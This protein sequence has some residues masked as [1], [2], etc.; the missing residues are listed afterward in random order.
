VKVLPCLSGI[1]SRRR[2]RFENEAFGAARIDHPH[3]TPV[4]AMGTHHGAMYYAMRLIRGA[5]LA[6]IVKSLRLCGG[7]ATPVPDAEVASFWRAAARLGAQA[8]DALQAAHT[9]GIVH[10]DVKPSNLLVDS[11]GRV[12]VT[13]FGLAHLAGDVRLTVSGEFVGTPR[14]AAPETIRRR[15]G[16]RDERVDVYG[17]GVS[18]YELLARRPAFDGS[19]LYSVLDQVA[20]CRPRRL[21]RIDPRIPRELAAIVHRA[22]AKR[23]KARFTT[24]AELRDALAQFVATSEAQPLRIGGAPSLRRRVP[25]WSLASLAL[26]SVA[27]VGGICSFPRSV[28][29]LRPSG[30]QRSSENEIAADCTTACN[31]HASGLQAE[32]FREFSVLP[33]HCELLEKTLAVCRQCTAQ[34]ALPRTDLCDLGDCDAVCLAKP[35]ATLRQSDAGCPL[36]GINQNDERPPLTTPRPEG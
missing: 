15:L 10:R 31:L 6:D 11:D 26:A 30:S 8:A 9:A 36:I 23:P 1:S 25:G 19:Q 33:A 13:D 12:W 29:W 24:A 32:W 16:P 35:V 2:R 27:G 20:R 5:S 21:T 17:L 3:V 28:D 34:Q 7:Q 22:I 14:Y 4:Y 18:L